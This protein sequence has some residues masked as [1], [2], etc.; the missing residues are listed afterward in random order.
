MSIHIPLPD[1][2]SLPPDIREVVQTAP[3]QEAASTPGLSIP[4]LSKQ[5]ARFLYLKSFP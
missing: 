3:R 2:E 1:I 5:L 4:Y